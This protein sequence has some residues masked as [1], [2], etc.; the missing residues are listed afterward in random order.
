MI[1]PIGCVCAGVLFASAAALVHAIARADAKKCGE[2]ATY[3]SLE[4]CPARK[5]T[6]CMDNLC[7][8]HCHKYH[9]EGCGR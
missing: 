6:L 7:V 4:R 1:D 5:S 9:K 3:H 8:A 2:T